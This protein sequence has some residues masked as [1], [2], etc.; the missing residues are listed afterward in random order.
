MIAVGVLQDLRGQ[1]HLPARGLQGLAQALTDPGGRQG[2]LIGGLVERRQRDRPSRGVGADPVVLVPVTAQHLVPAVLAPAGGGVQTAQGL[3]VVA[4]HELH[5][6][7]HLPAHRHPEGVT[8]ASEGHRPVLVRAE[9][10]LHP[11]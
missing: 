9:G 6:P 7:E 8:V 2:R 11:G 4:R 3:D 10:P 1:P 5:A